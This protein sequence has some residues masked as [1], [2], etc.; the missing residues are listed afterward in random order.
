MVKI[1]QQRSDGRRPTPFKLQLKGQVDPAHLRH[2]VS[3]DLRRDGQT[4][5]VENHEVIARC[6]N[7]LAGPGGARG[8]RR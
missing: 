1:R 2:F 8:G 6:P 5:Q 7:G 3:L 4:L